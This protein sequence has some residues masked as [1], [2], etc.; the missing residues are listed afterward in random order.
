MRVLALLLLVAGPAAATTDALRACL[1]AEFA[2]AIEAKF[3]ERFPTLTCDM[4]TCP[5]RLT[6]SVVALVRAE[7]RTRALTACATE[8]CT[9]DLATRWRRAGDRL[10]AR[11]PIVLEG[12]EM[13]T[14]PPL[15]ARRLSDP[16][17]WVAP[18]PCGTDDAA[19]CAAR[20]ALHRL[21]SLEA[22]MVEA[23]RVAR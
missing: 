11:L 9:G 21:A 22:R 14:L 23:G 16:E 4:A 2:P 6:Q 5:E 7:C 13:G 18:R 3:A 17:A 15:Q 1:G 19:M 10:A 8:G 12:V 20:D